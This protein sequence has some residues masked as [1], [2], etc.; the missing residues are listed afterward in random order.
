MASK[1]ICVCFFLVLLGVS[2][3]LV[4]RQ[5]LIQVRQIGIYN[6]NILVSFF[7]TVHSVLEQC[8]DFEMLFVHVHRASTGSPGSRMEGVQL[9]DGQGGGHRRR[10][11]H[12]RLARSAVAF[13]RRARWSVSCPVVLL[14]C[15]ICRVPTAACANLFR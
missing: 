7:D 13:Y 12:A 8:S 6:S 3:N 15:G 14:L 10:R 11:H 2:S 4:D 9:A 1:G 5:V